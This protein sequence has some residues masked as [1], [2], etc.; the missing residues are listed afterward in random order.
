M[1]EDIYVQER[2]TDEITYKV[3][4]IGDPA[5]GKTSLIKKYVTHQFEKDYI[6]TVGVSISKQPVMLD[7]GG[8]KVKLTQVEND[9]FSVNSFNWDEYPSELEEAKAYIVDAIDEA[10]REMD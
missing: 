3:I 8:K 10:M 4:I 1:D 6:P 5:I 7:V 2:E 9:A